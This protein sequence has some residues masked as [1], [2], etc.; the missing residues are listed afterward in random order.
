MLR[1]DVM[2]TSYRGSI[3]GDKCLLQRY[4]GFLVADPELLALLAHCTKL[5]PS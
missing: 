5:C 4:T 1:K 3:I 2:L